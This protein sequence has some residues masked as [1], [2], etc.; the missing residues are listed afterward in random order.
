[1]ITRRKLFGLVAGAVVAPKELLAAPVAGTPV[2][3]IEML[4]KA[5]ATAT[6]VDPLA[7]EGCMYFYIPSPRSMFM[8]TG[9]KAPEPEE[10]P[11]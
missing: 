2:F 11:C 5:Y 1:M 3:S 6:F 8:I 7:P 9:I 4:Q 10:F